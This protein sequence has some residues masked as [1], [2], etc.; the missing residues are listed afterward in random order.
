MSIGAHLVTVA[1]P[2]GYTAPATNLAPDPSAESG[3]AGVWSTNDATRYPVTYDTAIYHTGA[4]SAATVRT[5]ASASQLISSVNLTTAQSGNALRLLVTPGTVLSMSAMV[6]A[7]QIARPRLNVTWRDAAGGSISSASGP[8]TTLAAVDTWTR[9]TYENLVAPAGTAFVQIY[10]TLNTVA[11]NTVGGETCWWDSLMVNPGPTADTYLDGSM[12]G[13]QWA[14]TPWQSQSNRPQVGDPPADLS[15]LVDQV[16]I[17]HGRTDTTEQPAAATATIDLDLE[18]TGL[19]AVVEVGAVVTVTTKIAATTVTRFVGTLTDVA[20]GWDDAGPDTPNAG[21]GQLIA[22]ATLADLGRRVIGDVPW[23]QE[24][25]G[26][27][28]TRILTAAGYPAAPANVDPGQVALLARDVDSTDALQLAQDTAATAGGLLWQT[29]AGLVS[30]ADALHRKNLPVTL[31]LDSCDIEVTPTWAKTLQGLINKVS[32]GYGVPAQGA[33][34]QPRYVASSPASIA[35]YGTYDYSLTTDLAAQA[36]AA[37]LAGLLLARNSRPVWVMTALPIYV[38]D[39]TD[40]DTLTLL[41]FEV[42]SLL[43]LTG[44]PAIAAGTPTTALLWVEGWSETLAAGVHDLELVVSGYCRTVPPPVWDDVTATITW[45][46]W[47]QGT[48]DDAA[49]LGPPQQVDRW[50]DV[51]AS[52]R[53]DTTP[54][55]TTWD[56]WTPYLV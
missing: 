52:A 18:N 17:A 16:A 12:P 20:L 42:H 22:T 54:P 51:P 56:T 9:I 14:G 6:R 32:I 49:C 36:D 39:L 43:S 24:N 2:A 50:T 30:Y 45:D 41:G 25:D 53:W 48:W 13:C 29:R 37:A 8:I 34:D 26:A 15:C 19:P 33:S 47:G 4:R 35:R 40:A 7:G 31:A 28:I 55:A 44:L 21:I 27:R 3:A 11:G 46:T 10:G 5:T 38:K 1:S 23:P